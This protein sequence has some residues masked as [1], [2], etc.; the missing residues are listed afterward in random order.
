[1]QAGTMDVL[2]SL[3]RYTETTDTN[4]GEKLQTWTE[5]ATAWAERKESENGSEQV[6]ADR[7]EHKQVVYY[8]IRYNSDITVKDRIVSDGL[9]FNI[10]NIANLYRNLY[11]KL[12]TEL[13][14]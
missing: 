2:V 10:V 7:R 1:M 4:T 3:Q 12:Q 14:E 13:T 6:N 9:N 8:T 5:Y 11:L